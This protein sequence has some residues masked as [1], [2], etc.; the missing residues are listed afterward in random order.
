MSGFS[1]NFGSPG[2]PGINGLDGL[3][4]PRGPPGPPGG[5]PGEIGPQGSEGPR[6]PQG[7]RGPPG[8]I[9]N[10]FLDTERAEIAYQKIRDN[11][12]KNWFYTASG[13]IGLNKSNPSAMLHIRQT[14]ANKYAIQAEQDNNTSNFTVFFDQPNNDVVIGLGNTKITGGIAPSN[15]YNLNVGNIIN[16]EKNICIKDPNGGT[17]CLGNGELKRIK[18]QLLGNKI[19]SYNNDQDAICLSR[20]DIDKLKIL[21][22]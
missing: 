16:V 14:P 4:G 8:N 12:Y 20:E 17:S 5:P 6:G 22:S 18:N 15:M 10:I 13:Q 11:M 19:C 1:I 7:D 3:M 9:D 2:S 21:I